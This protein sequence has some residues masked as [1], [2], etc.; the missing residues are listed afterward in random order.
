M[1]RIVDDFICPS[2]RY[3]TLS[4]PKAPGYQGTVKHAS[5]VQIETD[6]E[7]MTVEKW[8]ADQLIASNHGTK[9]GVRVSPVPNL[10]VCLLGFYSYRS[11][12]CVIRQANFKF[13][14]TRCRKSEIDRTRLM[15]KSLDRIDLLRTDI[16]AINTTRENIDH[17][18]IG[19][20]HTIVKKNLGP[21]HIYILMDQ[22]MFRQFHCTRIM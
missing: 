19:I 8:R 7:R 1:S 20:H 3:L 13:S 2:L 18:A 14:F 15:I 5:L 10:T 9:K 11:S 22:I 16:E 21:Q 6:W 17:I 4:V 12:A